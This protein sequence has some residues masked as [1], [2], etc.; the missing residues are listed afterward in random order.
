MIELAELKLIVPKSITSKITD[1]KLNGDNYLQCKKIVEINFT[2]H[3][4]KSYLYTDP[5]NSKMDEWERKDATLFGPLLNIIESK[6]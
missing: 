3:R 4:K 1:R 6:I 5:P 2:G